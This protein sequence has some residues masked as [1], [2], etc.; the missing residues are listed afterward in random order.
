MTSY[1]CQKCHGLG[2]QYSLDGYDPVAQQPIV[3]EWDCPHCKGTGKVA[4]D[5]GDPWE[6]RFSAGC[7]GN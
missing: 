5:Q 4:H 1:E 7:C 2:K 6:I 3:D